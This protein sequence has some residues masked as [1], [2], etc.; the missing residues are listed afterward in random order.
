MQTHEKNQVKLWLIQVEF[1][2][3]DNLRGVVSAPTPE[4]AVEIMKQ[5]CPTGYNVAIY[6]TAALDP[7]KL[8]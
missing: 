4:E 1:S 7:T 6:F 2:D 8:G 3:T 5:R